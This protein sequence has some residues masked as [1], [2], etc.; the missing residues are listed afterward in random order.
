[1]EKEMSTKVKVVCFTSKTLA[2]G[3]H[4]LMLRVTKDRQRN[5]ES[6]GVSV[7]PEHWDFEKERP[8]RNCPNREAIEKIIVDKEA[9]YQKRIIE[10]KA[11][12]K[13]F[14]AKT[15]VESVNKPFKPMTVQA[16]FDEKIELLRSG[17]SFKSADNYKY[18]MNILKEYNKHLNIP[19]SDIDW[20]WLNRFESFLKGKELSGN[21]IYNHL[22][23]LRAVYYMALKMRYAKEDDNPFRRDYSVS[24]LLE[25]TEKRALSEIDVNKLIAYRETYKKMHPASLKRKPGEKKDW[26]QLALDIFAFSYFAGGMSFTDVARLTRENIRDERRT[27]DDELTFTSNELERWFVNVNDEA[28]IEGDTITKRRKKTN[29]LIKIPLIDY[30]LDIINEYANKNNPYLFPVLDASHDTELKK[31][32]RIHR[33]IDKINKSLEEVRI[34]LNIPTKITT[35]VARHTQASVLYNSD[36][37]MENIQQIMG[38]DDIKTTE[39]YVKTLDNKSH[40]RE[41]MSSKLRN[42]ALDNVL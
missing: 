11:V 42:K 2:N 36:E 30:A 18:T 40:L 6:L 25:E 16:V 38:H 31:H 8:K 32:H 13:D 21:T 28:I 7:K 35:Y 14:T 41:S 23:T 19:F 17:N 4:P 12:G 26:T 34:T 10:N 3:E 33:M 15:L 22:K 9:E 37:P 27:A 29:K 24:R 20:K 5:Y 1:M 39:I